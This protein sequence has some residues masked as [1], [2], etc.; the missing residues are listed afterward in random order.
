MANQEHMSGLQKI[1]SGTKAAYGV[2]P[3]PIINVGQ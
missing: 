1:G 2:A 3:Q